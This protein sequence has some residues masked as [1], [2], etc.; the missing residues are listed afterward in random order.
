MCL[1]CL[2]WCVCLGG[3]ERDYGEAL[4][5]HESGA[6]SP[7]CLNR[8]S[9][10]W[11]GAC[12]P[13]RWAVCMSASIL[14]SLRWLRGSQRWQILNRLFLSF[15]F[16]LI[17]H[18][19]SLARSLS[20]ALS[21]YLSASENDNVECNWQLPRATPE[22]WACFVVV[23]KLFFFF[24]PSPLLSIFHCLLF[25]RAPCFWMRA[26]PMLSTGPSL[27]LSVFLFVSLK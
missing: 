3:G 7:Y 18:T 22:R 27:P 1:R 15:F 26:L 13:S 14:S 11:L 19:L 10:Y 20:L 8:H 6:R 5:L 24:P 16:F 9:D 2:H 25:P 17:T 21:P 12:S 4:D 23:L